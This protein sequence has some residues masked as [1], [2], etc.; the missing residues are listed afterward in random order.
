MYLSVRGC[1]RNWVEISSPPKPFHSETRHNSDPVSGYIRTIPDSFSW[2][3]E[4]Q[5]HGAA[6]VVHTH[7]KSCRSRLADRVYKLK[8]SPHSWIFTSVSVGSRLRFYL[9]TSATGRIG[10]QTTHK[11][12]PICDAPLK[13]RDRRGAA[14]LRPR[15]HAAPTVLVWT[16]ALSRN[17]ICV[18]AQSGVE[19]ASSSTSQW[20][21][22]SGTSI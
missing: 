20:Q 1:A 11:N 6:P 9:V 2:P 14:S 5:R 19:L 17:M 7:R 21:W 18:A 12:Y 8:P 4:Q 3:Y 22:N 13:I 15:N 10:V 16:E